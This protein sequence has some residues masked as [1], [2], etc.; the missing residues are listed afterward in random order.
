MAVDSGRSKNRKVL[1]RGLLSD[2]LTHRATK[3]PLL[4]TPITL[5]NCEIIAQAGIQFPVLSFELWKVPEDFWILP[6]LGKS[7][8]MFIGLPYFFRP[9]I[10]F[11]NGVQVNALFSNSNF[12][13]N[14]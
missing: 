3:K 4:E 13:F 9:L 1:C 14:R 2:P 7:S 8:G 12:L 11:E 5:G 10:V 6:K